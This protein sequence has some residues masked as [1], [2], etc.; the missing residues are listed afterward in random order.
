MLD[1]LGESAGNTVGQHFW[2]K[3]IYQEFCEKIKKDKNQACR[4]WSSTYP[5]KQCV[6]IAAAWDTC[7][8]FDQ[9]RRGG[10]DVLSAQGSHR[11]CWAEG[12]PGRLAQL[13]SAQ[14]NHCRQSE[15]ELLS[16]GHILAATQRQQEGGRRAGTSA[17]RSGQTKGHRE[18]HCSS[19]CERSVDRRERR[20]QSATPWRGSRG[21]SDA[22]NK[23]GT[24]M[25]VCGSTA[26]RV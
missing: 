22:C 17:P 10:V 26:L 25:H 11:E 20:V 16:C 8:R 14:A 5:G 24:H 9:R 7:Q 6:C 4:H 12:L 15:C 3:H 2:F 1:A 23:P 13:G 18:V 21:G 19:P